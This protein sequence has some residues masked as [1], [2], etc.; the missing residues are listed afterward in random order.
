MKF[1]TTRS[2]LLRAVSF[3]RSLADQKST[4]PILQCVLLSATGSELLCAATDASGLSGWD[5]AK[6][7]VE[8]EG[9]I[10]ILASRLAEI[11]KALPSGDVRVST[12]DTNKRAIIKA[13]GAD[14]K[15]PYLAGADFPKLPVVKDAAAL[16]EVDAAQLTRLID[17]VSFASSDDISRPHLS[18][19]LLEPDGELSRMVT[20]NGH[21]LATLAIPLGAQHAGA[22]IPIAGL[23]AIKRAVDG[24]SKV[25]LGV[26]G[27]EITCVA[28]TATLIV[29]T[30][31]SQFPPYR[32]VI[33]ERPPKVV[34]INR[35]ALAEAVKRAAIMAPSKDAGVQVRIEPNRVVIAAEN[36]DT[37]A[38]RETIDVS[39]GVPVMTIGMSSVYLT[40]VL[41]SIDAEEVDVESTG[42]LDPVVISPAGGRK[43]HLCV[44]MPVRL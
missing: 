11:A 40:K 10:A 12:D 22:F 43:D 44:V 5:S 13:G 31:A 19:A 29:R 38:A 17:A 26:S 4:A 3:A 39:H 15:V 28:G 37:G 25:R 42:E 41:D 1:K 35:L 2:D 8:Q 9:S 14:F 16:Q 36:P 7:T 24:A 6:A 23:H 33:P 20:T 34:R 27:Q 18:G 32:Q 30:G 21:M